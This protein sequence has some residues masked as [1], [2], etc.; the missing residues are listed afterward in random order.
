MPRPGC[1][2]GLRAC[3]PPGRA[4]PRPTRMEALKQKPMAVQRL[5]PRALRVEDMPRATAFYQALRAPG[6][7]EADELDLLQ[8]PRKRADG[9]ALL[10]K[11]YTAAGPHFR[12]F[13]SQDRA[14]SS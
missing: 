2:N 5:G 12:P 10:A 14:E 13:T 4:S 6:H 1:A 9:V 11:T 3:F 8:S 7:W